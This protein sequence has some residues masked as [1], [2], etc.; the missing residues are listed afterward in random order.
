FR[1]PLV[2]ALLACVSCGGGKTYYPVQGSV[3]VNGKPAE[4]V[5][6][7]FSMIDDPDPEPARPTAGTQADGSFTLGTYL[8]KERVVKPGAPAGRYVV[9]CVWL[10]PEATKVGAGQAVPDKLQG[11]YVDPKASPL[12]AEIPEHAVELQPFQLEVGNQ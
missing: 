1:V 2:L 7:I 4:G 6:V 8:T 11:R 9:T 3:L 12:R 5:T 10:P